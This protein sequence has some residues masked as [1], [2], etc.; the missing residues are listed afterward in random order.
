VDGRQSEKAVQRKYQIDQS[1]HGD[2]NDV[3]QL[4]FLRREQMEGEATDTD[5]GYQANQQ[6]MVRG[7]LFARAPFEEL[8]PH[9]RGKNKGDI[10]DGV[11][12]LCAERR[13]R[14]AL[15]IKDD[16]SAECHGAHSLSAATPGKRPPSPE[17][18]P[19]VVVASYASL[20]FGRR[21]VVR[22]R[23]PL[24]GR[25]LVGHCVLFHRHLVIA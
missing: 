1:E 11:D 15:A 4:A 20:L 12:G 14:A 3:K 21:S 18:P 5:Q 10:R 19:P 7:L 8:K 13:A 24:I 2:G 16:V 17:V 25:L 6:E 22:R 9:E 23:R